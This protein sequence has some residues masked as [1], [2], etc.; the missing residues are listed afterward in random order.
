MDI[1]FY[2]FIERR[3]LTL[4]DVLTAVAHIEEISGDDECAHGYED[5]LHQAVLRSIAL[6]ECENP[7]EYAKEALKTLDLDFARWCA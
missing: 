6:G 1:P 4:F 2:R 5:S 3:P 7:Q